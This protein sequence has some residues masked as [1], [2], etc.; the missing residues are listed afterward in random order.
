MRNIIH[1]LCVLFLLGFTACNPN[2]P[3]LPY[4]YET[5]PQYTKVLEEFYGAYYSNYNCKNNVLTLSLFTKDLGLDEQNQLVGLGQCLVFTDVFIHPKD[6]I[7]PE[8]TYNLA[9][10]KEPFTFFGGKEFKEKGAISGIPS[11]AYICYVEADPSKN[12]IKYITEG[13]FTVSIQNKEYTIHCN[14]KTDDKKELKGTFKGAFYFT[15]V[16]KKVK[17]RAISFHTPFPV[18]RQPIQSVF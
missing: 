1:T 18:P 15:D 3:V 7:L 2:T 13:S 6:T 11:G 10:T 12:K 5:N 8:G 16:S 17:A 4:A 14:F 9:E